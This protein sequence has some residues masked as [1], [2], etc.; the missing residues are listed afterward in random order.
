M[1]TAT[2]ASQ[3]EPTIETVRIVNAPRQLVFEA[4]S[5]EKYITQWWGPNGF[6]NR[7]TRWDFKPGGK[8][9]FTMH[10]NELGDFPNVITFTE[11][12]E[13]ELICFDH[14]DNENPKQ[15]TSRIDFEDEGK[16]TRLT[17]KI[18]FPTIADRDKVIE[19][20]SAIRGQKETF[21]KLETF[22]AKR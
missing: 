3:T 16:I 15:F 11:I 14:G 22:L 12:I 17:M 8:W 13:D 4:F 5:E 21:D 2:I 7:D 20:V 1:T 18:T 6:S 9:I 19:E 10:H